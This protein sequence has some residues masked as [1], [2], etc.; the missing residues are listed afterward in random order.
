MEAKKQL[1]FSKILLDQSNESILRHNEL[2]AMIEQS[3]RMLELDWVQEKLKSRF[4][5]LKTADYEPFVL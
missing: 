3:S 2:L 1:K 4:E 5:K